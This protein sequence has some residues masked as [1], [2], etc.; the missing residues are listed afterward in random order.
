MLHELEIC[1]LYYTVTIKNIHL[2]VW[3]TYNVNKKLG[4]GIPFMK[5]NYLSLFS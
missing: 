4:I 3:S 1:L 2:G 5:I